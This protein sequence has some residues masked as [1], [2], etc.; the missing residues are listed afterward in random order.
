[1]GMKNYGL[2]KDS[3]REG[4]RQF[5][6]NW[7]L[8]RDMVNSQMEDRQRARVASNPNAYQGVDDYMSTYRVR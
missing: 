7:G 8:Q 2:M 6:M 5:D 3:L 4:K 1:M